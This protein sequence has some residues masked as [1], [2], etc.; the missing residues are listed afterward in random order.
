MAPKY[1][2]SYNL[3]KNAQGME[4]ILDAIDHIEWLERFF[5]EIVKLDGDSEND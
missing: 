5:M 1:L 4:I 3:D 2:G